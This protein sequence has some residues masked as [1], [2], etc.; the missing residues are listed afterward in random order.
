[1]LALAKYPLGFDPG[2]KW[3]YH[4]SS[5]ML[6]YLVERISG[7]TL[8]EYVK[9][10]ILVP[11]GM[12]D[13]DWYYKPAALPRFVKAYRVANGKL[14]PGTNIYSEGTVSAAADVC[15]GSASA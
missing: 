8:R 4:M 6:A 1:M 3:N 11:L 2:T 14:E 5:N 15:R 7:K 13:T 10:K 12:N 9:E